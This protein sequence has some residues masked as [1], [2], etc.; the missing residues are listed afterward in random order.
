MNQLTRQATLGALTSTLLHDLASTMKALT[1]REVA[2]APANTS[3]SG[4]F[5]GMIF[6][7]VQCA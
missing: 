7:A 2:A 3:S 5:C 6:R 1:D 4:A